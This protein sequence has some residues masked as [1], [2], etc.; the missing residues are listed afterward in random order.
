MNSD[1]NKDIFNLPFRIR[2][3][4]NHDSCSVIKYRENEEHYLFTGS[5]KNTY[6][7]MMT[8][9]FDIEFLKDYSYFLGFKLNHE[10]CVIVDTVKGKKFKITQKENPEEYD[11]LLKLIYVDVPNLQKHKNNLKE[12][13]KEEYTNQ[14]FKVI[15]SL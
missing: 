4:I 14:L 2:K 9:Q 7:T 6:D 10:N 1:S 5:I 13:I 3:L 12:Q 11:E 8:C 15:D